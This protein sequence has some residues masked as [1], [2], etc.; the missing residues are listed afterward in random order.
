MLTIKN[1]T[2]TKLAVPKWF[3]KQLCLIQ[4]TKTGVQF[5][6][7]PISGDLMFA[8]FSAQRQ[9]NRKLAQSLGR[10]YKTNKLTC[11]IEMVR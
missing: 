10:Q 6:V 8:F 5:K 3:K 2:E 11:R 7:K 9:T 1:E 4:F